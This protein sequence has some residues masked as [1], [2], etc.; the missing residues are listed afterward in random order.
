MKAPPLSLAPPLSA[1]GAVPCFSSQLTALRVHQKSLMTL[2]TAVIACSVSDSRMNSMPTRISRLIVAV[3]FLIAPSSRT[4]TQ[5]PSPGRLTEIRRPESSEGSGCLNVIPRAQH[6][7]IDDPTITPRSVW[8]TREPILGG[9]TDG[10][11]M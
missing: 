8:L 9:P 6:G 10:S 1:A 2:N 3:A 7:D 11:A 4:F 5:L